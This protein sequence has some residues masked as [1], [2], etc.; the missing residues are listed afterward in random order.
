MIFCGSPFQKKEVV[1]ALECFFKYCFDLIF[2]ALFILATENPSQRA[3]PSPDT[4]EGEAK[5]ECRGPSQSESGRSS[6]WPL[7]PWSL[8][9]GCLLVFR[10][11]L[12]FIERSEILLLKFLIYGRILWPTHNG[13]V[14]YKSVQSLCVLVLWRRWPTSQQRALL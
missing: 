11:C 1:A 12:L 3:F 6:K 2:I 7:T 10:Q 8:C 14:S 4:L 5:C 9:A 13:D